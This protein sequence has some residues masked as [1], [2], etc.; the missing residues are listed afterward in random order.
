[1]SI[2]SFHRHIMR[3]LIVIWVSG[4][5]VVITDIFILNED[6]RAWEDINPVSV[7]T[8]SNNEED[9]QA[10]RTQH[11]KYMEEG[12]IPV[13]S[14]AFDVAPSASE[15]EQDDYDVALLQGDA[16]ALTIEEI[17]QSAKQAEM[18]EQ[19]EP[20]AGYIGDIFRPEGESAYDDGPDEMQEVL[21]SLHRVAEPEFA[22]TQETA[23]K[24]AYIS[25]DVAEE[26]YEYKQSISDDGKIKVA[27]IIDDMGLT[28]RSKQ[29]EVM[30]GPLTL[31]YLPYAK[32]LQARVDRAQ[33]HGHEIML[34]IPMEAMNGNLDGGPKVLR[35]DL[36]KS[37]FEGI[38]NWGLS[39][40]TGFVG[41]NNHMGSRLTKDQKSMKRL[42]GI[43]KT[44]NVYFVDSKTIGSSVAAKTAAEYGIPHAERD[45]FLDH[46]ISRSFVDGAL[47]KLERV[48]RKNGVAIAIG[49]PHKVTIEALKDWMP[50]L[51]GKGISLVPASEIVRY[52]V[53]RNGDIAVN[54]TY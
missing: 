36:S 12:V 11:A 51:A 49:H 35:T 53:E 39:Q 54:S 24:E 8:F 1:M 3:V 44:Q 22:V 14:S 19:I 45:V 7:F 9:I 43:L 15:L 34:H 13:A 5:A 37:D 52:P 21:E 27:I 41:V 17:L 16:D 25:E 10:L 2:D 42:M 50:T 6:K 47:A 48:A 46:E 31:S 29:I 18:V 4:I 20:A 33:S 32:G 38:V 40:F 30:Q 26:A 23:T 28:L